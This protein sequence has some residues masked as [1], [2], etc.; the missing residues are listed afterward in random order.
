MTIRADSGP[1]KRRIRQLRPEVQ[2]LELARKN[3]QRRREAGI[4]R[5]D[6]DVA[7]SERLLARVLRLIDRLEAQLGRR[8]A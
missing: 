6:I 2:E 5:T 3:L 1:G 4:A 7:A 8:A